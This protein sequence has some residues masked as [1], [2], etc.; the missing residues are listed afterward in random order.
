MTPDSRVGRAVARSFA[1]AAP[2]DAVASVGADSA[3]ITPVVEARAVVSKPR[4]ATNCAAFDSARNSL[5]ER[6]GLS[7]ASGSGSAART[8]STARSRAARRGRGADVEGLNDGGGC[9]G[10]AVKYA[11]FLRE[12]P[13]EL[14]ALLTD[15]G[16]RYLEALD[17][18]GDVE[19]LV[20]RPIHDLEATF[21][22]QRGYVKASVGRVTEPVQRVALAHAPD[23]PSLRAGCATV[24][25]AR[26]RRGLVR[27]GLRS[28]RREDFLTKP[29]RR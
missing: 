6:R 15:E 28:R 22:R 17:R 11:A 8:P 27:S 1:V 5:V 20:M 24:S 10:K 7:R 3:I 16:L 9:S 12:A 25:G 29:H 2:V 23:C 18:N 19:G 21:A 14:L 13:L 26:L 4:R